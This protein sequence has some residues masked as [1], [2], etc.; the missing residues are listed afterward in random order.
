MRIFYDGYIFAI[1][2]SGGIN[3]YFRN[4]M[5]RLPEDTTAVLTALERR[6]NCFPGNRRVRLS[7]YPEKVSRLGPLTRIARRCY[8]NG[9]EKLT[10][11]DVAHPT[12]H[13]LLSGRPF[14][15]CK[16]PIV[17]TVHDM[18]PEIFSSQLDP[19]GRGAEAKRAA[20]AAADAIICV[21]E[22]TK[23]D[24]I[25]MLD[26]QEE[27]VS[28]I[29]LASELS[30]EMATGVRRGLDQPYVLFVGNRAF[31]KNFAR[32]LLAMKKVT[33]SWPELRILVVGSSFSQTEQE[34]ISAL[35][36]EKR[37]AQ[38]S[39][40]SDPEL[41]GLYRDS[42]AFV[43]PSLYEGF[44]IP[45]LEA[46]ACGTVVI[47]ARS[48]SIPEVVGEDAI[49]FD[50]YST[51]ELAVSILSLREIGSSRSEYIRRGR[52]RAMRYSWDRTAERTVDI[53]RRYAR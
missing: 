30:A 22:N 32:L 43:Y 14:K 47:A 23:R 13:E 1:Q 45:P 3:R 42:E 46:M 25:R 8:L 4:I 34:W 18:I 17:L 28:V 44:G 52:E 2:R 31:Y 38:V 26:V 10:S 15:S 36:L 37:I 19:S 49:L 40:I 51:E 50:P 11:A 21:S 29:P 53:Y 7:C 20:V 6:E 27:R 41:A 48:S 39:E 5:D 35:G 16:I 24:L 9:V 33:Q 12:Y